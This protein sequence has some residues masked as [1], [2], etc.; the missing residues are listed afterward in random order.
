MLVKNRLTK[1]G[2]IKSV[3]LRVNEVVVT[4]RDGERITYTRNTSRQEE[5]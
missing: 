5:N 2:D 3:V 1:P 4:T